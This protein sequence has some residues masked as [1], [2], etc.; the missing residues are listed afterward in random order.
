MET[1]LL[2]LTILLAPVLFLLVICLAIAIFYAIAIYFTVFKELF[3]KL[4]SK[5]PK[6]LSITVQQAEYKFIRISDGVYIGEIPV[7]QRLYKDIVGSNPSQYVHMD[8]PVHN[9]SIDNVDKFCHLLSRQINYYV[10]LPTED[11]WQLA[12]NVEIDLQNFATGSCGPMPV[13][14]CQPNSLGI[15]DLIDN[16]WE[17]TK[18]RWPGNDFHAVICGGSWRDTEDTVPTLLSNYLRGLMDVEDYDDNTGFRVVIR[19]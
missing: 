2:V 9:V 6:E 5:Q 11:E 14:Q 19:L 4:F 1:F 15:Y 8:A 16:V 17:W 12:A 3:R 13:K 10:D 18:T 7:T